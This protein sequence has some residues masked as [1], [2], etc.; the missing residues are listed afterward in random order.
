[1]SEKKAKKPETEDYFSFKPE[2][3]KFLTKEEMRVV[4]DYYII[5]QALR[6]KC[7]T[8]KDIHNLYYDK[9][10]QMHGYTIKTIYRYIEKLEK[11]GLIKEAGYR[12]TK[13]TNISEKI[14]CRAAN[15][16]YEEADD[17][18]TSW[19][20]TP[21]GKGFVKSL[22][23]LF[24]EVLEKSDFDHKAFYE[25]FKDFAILKD[26]V[27]LEVIGKASEN[28]EIADLYSKLDIEYVNKLN[29]YLSFL[30]AFMKNPEF[31]D[32]FMKLVM[33]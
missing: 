25:L 26:G 22:G 33:K 30:V 8:V 2:A 4:G 17:G 9:D 28:P 10:K 14:Y 27:V 15:L 1:M 6:K 31:L 5:M 21:E 29:I 11:V 7:M 24:S 13:G 12:I 32:K 3:L 20:E 19:Y 23:I 16:F 18:K